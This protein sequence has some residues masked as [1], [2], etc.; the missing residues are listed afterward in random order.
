MTIFNNRKEVIMS[1]PTD[2]Q[3]E[4]IGMRVCEVALEIFQRCGSESDFC[5]QHAWVN[6]V[7]GGTNRLIFSPH[8]GWRIDRSDCTTKFIDCW[9]SIKNDYCG[10]VDG[11]K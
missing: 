9:E 6:I 5:V 11:V 10:K 4:V 3:I 7:F 8:S 1:K 2:E